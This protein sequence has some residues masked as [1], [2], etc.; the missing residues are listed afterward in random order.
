MSLKA[1]IS[2]R[3]ALVSSQWFLVLKGVEKRR[4]LY[5]LDRYLVAE[6]KAESLDFLMQTALT[7]ALQARRLQGL[8]S[9]I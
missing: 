1:D 6:Y 5:F 2:P 9:L 4:T 8:G 3:R 7:V